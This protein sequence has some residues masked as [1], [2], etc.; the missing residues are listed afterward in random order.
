MLVLVVGGTG[1]IGSRL[2]DALV[3]RG[4]Q[5]TVVSRD[6]A[7][8]RNK[9]PDGVKARGYPPP[10]DGFDAVVNLAGEGLFDRRW[11]DEVKQEILDSRVEV[12]REVVEAI[13]E[14]KRPPRVLINGSAVGIYGDRG[15]EELTEASTHG[16]DFLAGVCKAWEAEA[17]KASCRTVML[18]TG[19]VLH[20]AGG[21]LAQMMLP[22]KL[23]AGG[24]IG[25]GKQW[26]PW[27]HIADEVGLILWALDN[28]SVSGPV[29]AVA[30]NVVRNKEFTKAFGKALKRPTLIPIPPIG[31][32]VV[33]GEVVEV[34]TGS[35]RCKPRVAL[36]GGY[37]FEHPE[38]GPAMQDLVGKNGKASTPKD[39]PETV[40]A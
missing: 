20:P 33:L 3:A 17:A 11:N 18:R 26:F 15:D 34:L 28:E 4:D 39:E 38:I 36:D 16:D 6:P 5:V 8:A 25:A 22:F 14:A 40:P 7:R 13:T 31:L 12:T 35:Q 19:V 23:G 32:R 29:N 1:F 10:L 9:V 30:P 37:T 21:A 2:V 24:P 27:I